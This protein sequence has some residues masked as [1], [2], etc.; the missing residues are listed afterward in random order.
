MIEHQQRMAERVG[1]VC[2]KLEAFD[3]YGSGVGSGSGGGSFKSTS[4]HN[5]HNLLKLF[6]FLI[7]CSFLPMCLSCLFFSTF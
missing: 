6:F 2:E 1:H 4:K 5:L 7:S 3:S